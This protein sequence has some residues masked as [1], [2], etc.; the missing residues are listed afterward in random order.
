MYAY[1]FGESKEIFCFLEGKSWQKY[2]AL[3]DV[4]HETGH[5]D[6]QPGQF[7]VVELE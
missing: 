4:G 6:T 1:F 7:C 3:I 2:L 5:L